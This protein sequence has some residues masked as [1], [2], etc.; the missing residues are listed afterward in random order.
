[1][2]LKWFAVML[3]TLYPDIPWNQIKCV[4]FDLDGTL[5]DEFDAIQQ[6]YRSVLKQQSHFFPEIPA[7]L[8]FM[9]NR[10]LEKGSS[11]NFIFGEAFDFFS[12]DL[13]RKEEFI[14][15]ALVLFRSYAPILSLAERNRYLLDIF[16]QQFDLFM[17]S[18]GPSV[19]QRNK[20]KA[21]GLNTFFKSE[22]L[23]FTGDHGK[24]FYKPKTDLFRR[25]AETSKWCYS[26]QEILYFGDRTIDEEFTRNLDIRFQKVHNMVPK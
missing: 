13:T 16:Q 12:N 18:D 5:Y 10:W 24:K 22:Q 8:T 20:F 9:L 4:G 3:N 15:K 25:L 14:Q 6:I 7:A 2:A 26:N 1:M 11:Y 23:I 21:L 19:L 17:I